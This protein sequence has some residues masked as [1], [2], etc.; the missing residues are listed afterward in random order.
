MMKKLVICS[1]V[2]MLA[3]LLAVGSVVS[4]VSSSTVAF[5]QEGT[6]VPATGTQSEPA[7]Q[8]T[9]QDDNDDGFP[10][11]LLGLLGLGGLAGLRRQEPPTPTRVVENTGGARTYE[12]KK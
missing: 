5:A 4:G 10:W 1:T 7:V 9:Q 12:S 11:G 8:T 2:A 3:L 6:A